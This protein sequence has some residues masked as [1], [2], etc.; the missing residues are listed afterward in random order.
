M[1]CE[2]IIQRVRN[3]ALISNSCKTGA[4]NITNVQIILGFNHAELDDC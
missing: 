2:M 3:R 1:S 4:G